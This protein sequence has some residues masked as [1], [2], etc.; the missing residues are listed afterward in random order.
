MLE[1]YAVAT[2]LEYL[3]WM[4]FSALAV[5]EGRSFMDL[6]QQIMGPNVTIWDDGLDPLGLPTAIDYEGV[7]TRRG[8]LIT[9]GVAKAVVHGTA[10]PTRAGTVPT[11]HGVQTTP[12]YGPTA[13]NPLQAPDPAV[14]AL[15]V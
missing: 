14:K 8:D 15:R 9:D 3:S 7:P 6:G 1:E 4:G 11:G 12:A 10:N 2:I 13:M 5:E